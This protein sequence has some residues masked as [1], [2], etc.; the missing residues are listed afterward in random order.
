MRNKPGRH[1]GCER[2][3]IICDDERSCASDVF[4]LCRACSTWK[5]NSALPYQCRE[6]LAQW[7]AP[8]K[9]N[10]NSIAT[11]VSTCILPSRGPSTNSLFLI[12]ALKLHAQFGIFCQVG[13]ESIVTKMLRARFAIKKLKELKMPST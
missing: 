5:T 9:L 8:Y 11:I 1:G 6:V 2:S 13:Q 4:P 12:A 3:A 7:A 10:N